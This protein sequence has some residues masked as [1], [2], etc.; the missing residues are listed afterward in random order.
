METL[1]ELAEDFVG[2]DGSRSLHDF[3][4]WLDDA[5]R[6]DKVPSVEVPATG[7]FVRLM[8][9]H[10]SKGLEFDAVVLPYLVEGVF[11]SARGRK[12]WPTS[13]WP[14]RGEGPTW[15]WKVIRN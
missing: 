4:R 6:F 12:R 9:V 7:N 11:P 10:A 14:T 5:V 1:V 15:P 2:I 13:A 3:L 8:T